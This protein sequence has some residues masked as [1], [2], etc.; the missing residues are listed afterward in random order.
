MTWIVSNNRLG[1]QAIEVTSTV[2]NLDEGTIVNAVDSSGTQGGGEF[3]YLK[4]VANTLVGSLVTYDPVNHTTT[5][6]PNTANLAQP[7]AVS[8]SANVA[9][10]WGWY[11]IG[12]AAVI[13]KTAVKVSPNV[14]L[15]QSG[16]TGRVMSTA[17][18]GKQL[19]NARSVNAATVASATS[20][21]TAILDR[22]FLQGAV[23]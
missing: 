2:Q 20:T 7:V 17:A 5:L 15:Y 13:K 6:T 10:Q 4:G 3:I 14:A 18:S 8:M 23:A 22:P 19:V 12:G 16:T 21:I 1:V 11:Q 9:L